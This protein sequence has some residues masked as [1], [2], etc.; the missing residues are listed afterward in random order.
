MV[1][2]AIKKNTGKF[3]SFFFWLLQ[4]YNFRGN[5]FREPA[6]ERAAEGF[7]LSRFW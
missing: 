5:Q 2:G 4:Y 6:V 3:F 1:K 7:V